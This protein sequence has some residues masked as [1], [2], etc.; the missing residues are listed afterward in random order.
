MGGRLR[1]DSAS[2]PRSSG[3]SYRFLV[4][5]MLVLMLGSASAA[6]ALHKAGTRAQ[7]GVIVTDFYGTPAERARQQY[8]IL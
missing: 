5:A 4:I 7:V 2:I 1:L 8:D 6:P 3:F